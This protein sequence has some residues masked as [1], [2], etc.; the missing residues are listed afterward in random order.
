M[1]AGPDLLAMM[2]VEDKLGSLMPEI[3]AS[4]HAAGTQ[5]WV[6]MGVRWE[7]AE[8]FGY[9]EPLL[10]P[11]VR[12]VHVAPTR[13]TRGGAAAG[14]AGVG[15][16]DFRTRKTLGSADAPGGDGGGGGMDGRG[17]RASYRARVRERRPTMGPPLR[18]RERSTP[19][20]FPS[21]SKAL[22]SSKPNC[23]R[24]AAACAHG[25]DDACR[26]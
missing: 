5:Q 1:E 23:A 26:L 21:L 20:I 4:L 24:D 7:T 17:R 9:S 25:G 15:K 10:E 22:S 12:V 3:T 11:F 6:R 14:G 18:A 2:A 13:T 19:P 16:A 8:N